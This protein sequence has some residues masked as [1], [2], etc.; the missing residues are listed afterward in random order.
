MQMFI[1]AENYIMEGVKH[2]GA[3]FVDDNGKKEIIRVYYKGERVEL[4]DIRVEWIDDDGVNDDWKLEE[5]TVLD[6]GQHCLFKGIDEGSA[7]DD[8]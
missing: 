4:N 1:F 5:G 7:G 2:I 8:W 6:Y 3:L